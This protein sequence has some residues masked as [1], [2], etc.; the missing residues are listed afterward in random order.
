LKGFVAV[1]AAG[2][3]T[4]GLVLALAMVPTV[5]ASKGTGMLTVAGAASLCATTG[6]LPALDATQAANARIVA[7]VA[8]AQGGRQAA[9]IAVMTAITESSLRVLGN[10]NVVGARS[11]QGSGSNFDSVGLFQQRASWGTVAQR[12]DP[13]E[14]TDLFT[15]ALLAL[16]GWQTM[17]PW[18][19][20]QA[21]QRSAFTG[22]P[23]VANGFSAVVGGNYLANL[24]EAEAIVA[25]VGTQASTLA[26]GQALGGT[27]AGPASANGLPAGY[28]IPATATPAE[29]Q[30][31][32]FALAQL[33]KPYVWGAAGP[34]A[35]DCSGLT[36][37]AWASAGVQLAHYSV[38]QL[39]E[40]SPVASPALMAPGD[41][42]FAPGA[43]GTLA[44]PGHVGM[45]IGDGLVVNAADT[46][47][48]VIVQT[49]AN[50]V[51]F[52]GGLSGI[53]HI[54]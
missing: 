18:L 35:F 40:G 29:A 13:V 19:A 5:S 8:G 33:G 16:A 31:V 17:S 28:V 47:L 4:F 24:P 26:C 39:S 48:G 30:A 54:A 46:R 44:A 22:A 20:A 21:V 37:A 11:A 45:Y 27:P 7:A 53:R 41:L 14:S 3:T 38:T 6:P 9:V 36:M 12:L 42:I 23:S 34:G 10:P 50:F 15:T 43:D 51:R 52:A 1:G 32:S 2:V 49:Y 25:Q